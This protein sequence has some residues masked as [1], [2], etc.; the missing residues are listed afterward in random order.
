MQ[1]SLRITIS[2]FGY[3]DIITISKNDNTRICHEDIILEFDN[4]Y[5]TDLTDISI[6]FGETYDNNKM[7][8]GY[9]SLQFNN[10]F[11]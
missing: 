1:N 11:I 6:A 8:L 7:Y 4:S 2:F 10:R 5:A 3:I 9:F